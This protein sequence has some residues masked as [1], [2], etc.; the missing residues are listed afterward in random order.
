MRKGLVC[1]RIALSVIG[2]LFIFDTLIISTRSNL[3]LGV[4]MPAVIGL[5]L[6]I[7]G[8]FYPFFSE[9]ISR[10]LIARIIKW[11]LIAAY[12]SFAALFTTTTL[13]INAAESDYPADKL[14]A[15]IVLGCGIRGDSPTLVLKNRLDRAAEC[16]AQ[17]D[18]LIIV[19]SGGRGSGELY[20][21]AHVMKKYLL[22]R[23]VPD[24]NI[25][26]EGDSH[27]TKENFSFSSDIIKARLGEEASIAFVTTKFH[28]YR[29]GKVAGAMGIQA[30]GIAA[31]DIWYLIPNNYLRECAAIV[32]YAV[33]GK[34]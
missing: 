30:H 3:N 28:V 26:E 14:D 29:A 27:S 33:S 18:D 21:E 6:L 31:D 22:S 19:V 2:A 32:Q 8:V 17:N 12:A 23:G 16:Y 1:M 15:I 9:L 25:V 13:I 10:Y 34:I 20:T 4:V 7:A 11:A 24:E 5:P